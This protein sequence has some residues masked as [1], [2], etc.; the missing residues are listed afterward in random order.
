VDRSQLAL[1]AAYAF[2]NYKAQGQTMECVLVDLG[3]PPTSALTGFNAYVALSRSRG[4]DTIRLLR[5][6]NEKLFTVHPSE[7][8]RKE[9]T[10]LSTLEMLTL[11]RYINGKFG[12]F[13]A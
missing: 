9:D 13:V 7:D 12:S 1:T 5:E 6:F 3:K 11:Q 10:R 2:T 4:R 8:L